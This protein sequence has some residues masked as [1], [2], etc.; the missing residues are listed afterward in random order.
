VCGRAQ[1]FH[2]LAGE[3]V[4]SDQMDFGVTVLA[5]L[6]GGH[7][8]DLARAVLDADVSVLPQ[9]R[10]LHGKSVGRTSIGA[11]EGVL[12]LEDNKSER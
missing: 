1:I 4:D 6:R 10:A 5:S 3:N 8:D 2:L 12:M 7:F 11:V 9:S